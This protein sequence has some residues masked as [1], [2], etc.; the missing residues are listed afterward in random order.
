MSDSGSDTA[1]TIRNAT[2]ADLG[3]LRK[4]T[5]ETIISIC[6]S[7]YDPEQIRVWSTRIANT[8][9]WT[10]VLR[11]QQVWVAI[12]QDQIAGYAT[13]TSENYLDLFYVHM[14]FQGRGIARVLMEQVLHAAQ[15]QSHLPVR[16]HV[17]KTA[18]GFFLKSGFRKIETQEVVLDGIGLTN[19]KMEFSFT[20]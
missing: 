2:L 5:Q 10:D 11:N 17:S 20:T 4:L 6:S 18:L 9:R 19:Y 7:D 3:A 12:A 13:L 16:A 8:A 14:D 1:V 15:N